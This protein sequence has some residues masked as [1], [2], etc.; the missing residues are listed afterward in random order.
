MKATVSPLDALKLMSWST[1]PEVPG[2]LKDTFLNST[3]PS[4]A[5][6]AP[7]PSLMDGSVPMTSWIRL[8][9]TIARGRI[10]KIMTS[11]MNAMTI[12]IA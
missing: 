2:Y 7:A 5:G 6:S 11:M 8:E 3:V 1:S 9:A 12:C 4:L 10:M